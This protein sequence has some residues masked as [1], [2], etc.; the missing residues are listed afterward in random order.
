MPSGPHTPRQGGF[1]LVE[2]VVAMAVILVG[3]LGTLALLDRASAQTS[4]AKTRQTANAL[5]R[6][7]IETTQGVAYADLT[8]ANIANKLKA[9][10]FPDDVPVSTGTWD[11]ER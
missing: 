4:Q 8:Q 9:N 5:I 11:V 3:S 1:T 2:V 10:G 7:I 6:D